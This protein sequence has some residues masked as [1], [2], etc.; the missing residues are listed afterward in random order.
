MVGFLLALVVEHERRCVF[1]QQQHHCFRLMGSHRIHRR[2]HLKLFYIFKNAFFLLS[3]KFDPI[4]WQIP[5]QCCNAF[6]LYGKCIEKKYVFINEEEKM[7]FLRCSL[8]I[9]LIEIKLRVKKLFSLENYVIISGLKNLIVSYICKKCIIFALVVRGIAA[10][11]QSLNHFQHYNSVTSS[12]YSWHRGKI[13][14]CALFHTLLLNIKYIM[15]G[16]I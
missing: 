3:T 13:V 4:F 6:G 15:R 10:K 14:C 2:H 11:T 12:T 16:N 1:A 5:Y 8:M 9:Q 7:G